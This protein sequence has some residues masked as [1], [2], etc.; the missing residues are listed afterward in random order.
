M[1]KDWAKDFYESKSWRETRDYLMAKYNFICQK[2]KNQP[3]E[4]VHHI[5]WLTP[6]NINN[7]KITL[8]E[9]NLIPVCRD[10]HAE[11]HYNALS[12][13]DGL[14]FDENGELIRR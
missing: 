13:A 7:P 6:Q 14:K 5:I 8:C 12:T 10:C 2:C 3:A 4:I 11:Y 1:A 9:D